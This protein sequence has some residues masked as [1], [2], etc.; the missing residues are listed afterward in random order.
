MTL[1]LAA[2]SI[3]LN[4][5]GLYTLIRYEE[6]LVRTSTRISLCVIEMV[7]TGLVITQMFLGHVIILKL[8]A[9]LAY[10]AIMGCFTADAFIRMQSAIS[11]NP[12][13][14]EKTSRILLAVLYAGAIVSAC[15][16]FFATDDILAR[17]RPVALGLGL[18]SSTVLTIV[19]CAVYGRVTIKVRR[20]RIAPTR[21]NTRNTWKV[22]RELYPLDGTD[23]SRTTFQCILQFT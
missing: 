9:V 6:G 18:I 12:R 13:Q 21:Q 2:I 19:I 20:A 14:R 17:I 7:L 1:V 8:I 11:Y 5:L 4:A 10:I 15:L 22:T 23:K 3:T 16:S